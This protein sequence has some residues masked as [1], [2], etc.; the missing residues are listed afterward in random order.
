MGISEQDKISDFKTRALAT[1]SVFTQRQT[2]IGLPSNVFFLG[3]FI[4]VG[5][6]FLLNWLSGIAFGVVYFYG[7][8]RIHEKDPKAFEIWIKALR[9]FIAYKMDRWR[10]GKTKSTRLIIIQ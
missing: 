2:I 8:Y 1:F 4:T 3:T 6:L 7:M 5:V 10:A 9:R